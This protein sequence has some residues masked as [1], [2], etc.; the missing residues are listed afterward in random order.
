MLLDVL[1]AYIHFLSMIATV[2]TLAVEAVL[3]RPGLTARG[4]RL[5][6]RVDIIYFVAAIL[7]LTSGLLRVFFGLKGAAFYL[8]NPVFYVKIGLFLVVGLLSIAP[9]LQFIRWGRA[10]LDAPEQP[11]AAPEV[12]RAARM[13]YIELGLLA[14]IP[15]M[16]VLMARGYGH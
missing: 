16:G 9:T 4:A 2:S 15:L 6:S 13:V 5:L 11:V 7:V 12:S 8:N 14:L 1:L 10:T 3:C